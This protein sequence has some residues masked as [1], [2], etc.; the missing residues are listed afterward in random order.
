MTAQITTKDDIAIVDMSEVR[1]NRPKNQQLSY[2]SKKWCYTAKVQCIINHHKVILQVDTSTIQIHDVKL[3][4][5]TSPNLTKAKFI[6]ADSGYQGIQY[7]YKQACTLPKQTKKHLL[8]QETKDYN[9]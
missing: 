5:L 4:K 6:L 1:V 8:T 9:A 7:L 3:S 2:S